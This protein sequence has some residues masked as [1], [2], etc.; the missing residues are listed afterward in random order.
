MLDQ[1]HKL[2]D[3]ARLNKRRASILNEAFNKRP[4]R[5]YTVHDIVSAR[6][7]RIFPA[8]QQQAIALF[9]CAKCRAETHIDSMK[10]I[11][12]TL[13]CRRCQ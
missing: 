10:T 1:L 7:A 13:Y 6:A 12:G 4:A 8:K 9:P 11:R 3:L 5:K 2:Q